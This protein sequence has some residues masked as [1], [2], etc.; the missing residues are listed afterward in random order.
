MKRKHNKLSSVL[1]RATKKPSNYEL[2]VQQLF[3]WSA[4][5]K[6]NPLGGGDGT[7]VPHIRTHT[8]TASVPMLIN[9]TCIYDDDGRRH[10]VDDGVGGVGGPRRTSA[11][12]H[13][14]RRAAAGIS[15]MVGWGFIVF[16]GKTHVRVRVCVCV[17]VRSAICVI[18]N[19]EL[20]ERSRINE[21]VLNV[22]IS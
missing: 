3:A 20:K 16:S 14:V 4:H 5:T 15:L 21:R 9:N 7:A 6:Y 2:S 11:P 17:F 18:A 22:V 12:H 8:H 19:T 1:F 10:S 13:T